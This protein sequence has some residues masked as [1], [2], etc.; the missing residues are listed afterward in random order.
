MA[1]ATKAYVDITANR[2]PHI[3]AGK[4]SLA[5][6]GVAILFVALG[7]LFAHMHSETYRVLFADIKNLTL[8]KSSPLLFSSAISPV[9]NNNPNYRLMFLDN[10]KQIFTDFIQWYLDLAIVNRKQTRQL[11]S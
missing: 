11:H 1:D 10:E 6:V 5:V 2:Y 8:E 3:I 4:K 7:Q 9:Y